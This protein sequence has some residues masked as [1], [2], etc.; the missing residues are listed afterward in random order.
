VEE[1]ESR[2]IALTLARRAADGGSVGDIA[3]AIVST[4]QDI[5]TTL[6][7]VLGQRG[8]SS[9]YRRSLHLST[10]NHAWL[11]DVQG[12]SATALDLDMLGRALAG[13]DSG[14]AA[15]GGG[16]LLQAFYELLAS[17]VGTSLTEQLLRSI[18]ANSSSG[19]S[20]QDQSR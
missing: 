2:R 14:T 20:A 18:W 15:A 17:L 4:W 6:R 13:Q 3:N 1:L 16:D 10:A 9:L 8:V 12:D 5:D 11:A 19:E 7:P